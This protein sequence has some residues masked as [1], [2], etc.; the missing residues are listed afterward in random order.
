MCRLCSQ[1]CRRAPTP[2]TSPLLLCA[3]ERAAQF[4][5]YTDLIAQQR[6]CVCDNKAPP[7]SRPSP[8]ADLASQIYTRQKRTFIQNSPAH[9]EAVF[10][11]T[12]IWCSP[13]STPAKRN[14]LCFGCLGH[15]WEFS[16]H[17]APNCFWLME[18]PFYVTY[19]IFGSQ[20]GGLHWVVMSQGH[21]KERVLNHF[22]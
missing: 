7:I 22:F 1:L 6:L 20:E 14:Q 19:G 9:T 15:K 12:G 21:C 10:L 4:Q 3:F 18:A 13:T 2:A 5:F 11:K 16:V 8:L 17:L